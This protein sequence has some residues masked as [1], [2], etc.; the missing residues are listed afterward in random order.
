MKVQKL[1]FKV[2]INFNVKVEH[3]ESLEVK[4]SPVKNQFKQLKGDSILYE[5][6]ACLSSRV[7]FS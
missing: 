5:C 1:E 6:L 4:M 7:Y 3:H 2:T